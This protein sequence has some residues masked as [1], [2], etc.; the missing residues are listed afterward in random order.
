MEFPVIQ[1]YLR[2]VKSKKV[3]IG[4]VGL[5]YVGLPLVREFTRGGVRVMG[6][7][8]DAAKVKS[9]LAGRSYIEHIPSG[10][11]KDMVRSGQFEPTTDFFQRQ[12]EVE[13]R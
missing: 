13:G 4:V 3:L 10:V 6:F 11:I 12:R 7:D 5:G 9:L 8:V 2:K 1:Q